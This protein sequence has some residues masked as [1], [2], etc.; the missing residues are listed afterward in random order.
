[1]IYEGIKV[2]DKVVVSKMVDGSYLVTDIYEV[3]NDDL[4]SS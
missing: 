2:N 1:M 4:L 3:Y